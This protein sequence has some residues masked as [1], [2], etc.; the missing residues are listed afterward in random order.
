MSGDVWISI[1][2]VDEEGCYWFTEGARREPFSVPRDGDFL[3][4]FDRDFDP[5]RLLRVM[6]TQSTDLVE[7]G[8]HY[9]AWTCFDSSPVRVSETT[10]GLSFYDS[11][12]A[13]LPAS[14]MDTGAPASLSGLLLDDLLSAG[15][16]SLA[17]L[18]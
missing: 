17:D 15:G 8:C 18:E 2:R 4:E 7:D 16:F 10:D 6:G 9:F 3:I 13:F 14:G 5:V 12:S 11:A 1:G